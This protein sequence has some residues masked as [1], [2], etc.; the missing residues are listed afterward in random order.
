MIP[1]YPEPPPFVL[2]AQRELATLEPSPL[3][4]GWDRRF[5]DR[6]WIGFANQGGGLVPAQHRWTSNPKQNQDELGCK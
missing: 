1:D 5:S 2:P 6:E 3:G 4:S